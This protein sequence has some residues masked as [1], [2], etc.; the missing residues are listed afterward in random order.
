MSAAFH[1]ACMP[2]TYLPLAK[3]LESSTCEQAVTL[4]LGI[5]AGIDPA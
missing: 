5:G 2:L 4:L 3:G 1:M